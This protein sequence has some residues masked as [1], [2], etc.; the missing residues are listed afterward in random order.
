MCGT[1]AGELSI[2]V[3]YA[4][5]TLDFVDD[6]YSGFHNTQVATSSTHGIVLQPSAAAASLVCTQLGSIA[7]ALNHTLK[8]LGPPPV[9]T[10]EE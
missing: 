7:T 9:R 8:V 1:N 2:R 6:P 4:S 5:G 3:D 10:A